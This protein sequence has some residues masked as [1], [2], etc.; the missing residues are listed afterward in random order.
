MVSW[1]EAQTAVIGAGLIEPGCVPEI[2]A[3]ARPEDFSGAFVR[4]YEAFRD[5]TADRTPIDPVSVLA[6]IGPDYQ[7]LAKEIVNA[8]PTAANLRAYLRICKDQARLR[9]LRELGGELGEAATLDQAREVMGRAAAVA[10]DRGRRESRTG[11]ELAARWINELNAD[12]KPSFI[13][14]G[15]GCIDSVVHTQPGNY[16]VIAGKTSHG[17]SALALQMAWNIAQEK[18][19][20]FFSNE[21]SEAEFLDRLIAMRGP[22][23]HEHV[24]ARDLTEDE[25]RLSAQACNELFKTKL[26]FEPASELTV[27]DIRAVTLRG[28]YEVI[29]VDYLQLI[30]VPQQ[31]RY[32]RYQIVSEISRG[33][34]MMAKNLGIVVFATCQLSRQSDNDEFEPV[35]PLSALR[36]SGQIEQDADAVIFVHG[37]MRKRYPRFRVLDIAKNRHGAVDRF[38][39]DFRVNYQRFEAP[40]AKDYRVW[41]EIMR[42]RRALKAE[43]I[44]ELEEKAEA[45]TRRQ[46]ENEQRKRLAAKKDGGGEQVSMEEVAK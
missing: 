5:L 29:F 34:A 13:T 37:P 1:A 28:G 7:D 21:M 17:K 43:E 46:L 10:V 12:A 23:D 30:S 22:V 16:H 3:E 9:L 14:C 42:L 27:D 20:G 15:I 40:S 45:D 33:L 4:F 6:R 35:P 18:K 19:V 32:D 25:M 2:L 26:T 31:R 39:I 11:M 24:R 41:R 38:F 44:R 36:E 8:T